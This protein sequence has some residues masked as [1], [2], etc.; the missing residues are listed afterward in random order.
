MKAR[1]GEAVALT[2]PVLAPP[3][4]GAG[5]GSGLT[6]EERMALWSCFGAA[7]IAYLFPFPLTKVALGLG[8]AVLFGSLSLRHFYIAVALFAF[9]LP[10][11]VLL[12]K[13]SFIIR[14]L[15]IETLFVLAFWILSRSGDA[16]ANQAEIAPRN[17]L[18]KPL[19]WMIGVA[20]FAALHTSPE[21]SYP[22][23][24]LFP[25]LEYTFHSLGPTS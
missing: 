1:F 23:V 14:G 4:A 5:T 18:A 6:S 8:L 2:P 25:L 3:D 11:Q 24:T 12:P 9:F 20:I 17:A 13:V 16:S 19:G 7:M 10:L 21:Y 22:F 15:N